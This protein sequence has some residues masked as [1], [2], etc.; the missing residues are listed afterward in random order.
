MKYTD[1][2]EIWLEDYVKTSHK[3]RTYARYEQI[4]RTHLDSG[5]GGMELSEL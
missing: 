5:L 2:L 3:P 1:W 4:K